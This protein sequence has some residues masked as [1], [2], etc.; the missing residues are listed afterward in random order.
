MLDWFPIYDQASANLLLHLFI[1][2]IILPVK[3]QRLAGGPVAYHRSQGVFFCTPAGRR[4]SFN[5]LRSD[6]CLVD[7]LF[8]HVQ[9]S[10]RSTQWVAT[11]TPHPLARAMALPA[12]PVVA[13]SWLCVPTWR[14]DALLFL[15]ERRERP[16]N[17]KSLMRSPKPLP[18]RPPVARPSGAS[19]PCWVA[20]PWP[21]CFPVWPGPTTAPAPTSAPRSLE[22]IHQR[23]P[24]VPVTPPITKV[25]ATPVGQRV[26]VAPGPFVAPRIPMAPA[27]VTVV[28][29]AVPANRSVKTAL[30]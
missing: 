17:P 22:P 28:P 2:S 23:L 9:E 5:L 16:W 15:N 29:P 13:V 8:E 14:A 26:L 10:W 27:T 30:A 21:G 24:S 3:T 20:R 6:G 7:Y 4:A 25:C 1:L 18:P 12:L 19:E 11:A